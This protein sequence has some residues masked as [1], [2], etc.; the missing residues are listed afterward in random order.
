MTHR[1]MEQRQKRVRVKS[2]ELLIRRERF[3]CAWNLTETV[4]HMAK[5][6]LLGALEFVDTRA[7]E[8][9]GPKLEASAQFIQ[10]GATNLKITRSQVK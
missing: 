3:P 1:V 7:S 4:S 6:S 10:P 8:A 2:D 9:S 5:D